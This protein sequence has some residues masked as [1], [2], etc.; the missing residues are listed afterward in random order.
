VIITAGSGSQFDPE[1]VNA[2]L[3][4]EDEFEAISLKHQYLDDEQ[5]TCQIVKHTTRL[6]E[7]SR[8]ES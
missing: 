5:L 3:A 8:V 4:H 6:S 1:V 7:L 2:F